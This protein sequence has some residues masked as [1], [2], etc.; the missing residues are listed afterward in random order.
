MPEKLEDSGK[1]IVLICKGT[2]QHGKSGDSATPGQVTFWNTALVQPAQS[3]VILKNTGA[4]S[5]RKKN[6]VHRKQQISA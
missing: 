1:D 2:E 6:N 5:R 3:S 4:Y